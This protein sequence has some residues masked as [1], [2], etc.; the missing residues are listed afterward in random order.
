MLS[1]SFESRKD[2]LFRAFTN[3]RDVKALSKEGT[4]RVSEYDGNPWSQL[5]THFAG[6]ESDVSAVRQQSIVVVSS[7]GTLKWYVPG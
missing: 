4:L 7:R 6:Q 1:Y 5:E 3:V 2:D